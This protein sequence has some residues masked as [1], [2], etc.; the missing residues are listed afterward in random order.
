MIG[1][2]PEAA[3]AGCRE[4]RCG[5]QR[6]PPNGS[7]IAEPRN[8]ERVIMNSAFHASQ[9]GIPATNPYNGSHTHEPPQDP[10]PGTA[11]AQPRT[12]QKEHDSITWH[13]SSPQ[14]EPRTRFIPAVMFLTC[15]APAAD[16]ERP[17]LRAVPRRPHTST[18][19]LWLTMTAGCSARLPRVLAPSFCVLC[20]S[21]QG[22]VG[23]AWAGRGR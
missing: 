10:T 22:A 3:G 12:A 8:N 4:P 13:S 21:R 5:L 1:Y 15:I 11:A 17:P 14:R 2:I 6:V 9:T 23:L 19:F 20:G 16:M 7:D 18:S